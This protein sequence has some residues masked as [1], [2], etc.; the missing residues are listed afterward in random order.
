MDCRPLS[1]GTDVIAL[2]K[3]VDVRCAFSDRNSG[4]TLEDA[5]KFHVFAPL[6]ALSCV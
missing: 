5:I 4:F 3:L 1:D 2:S 6:E